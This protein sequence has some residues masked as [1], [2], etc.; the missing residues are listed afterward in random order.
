MIKVTSRGWA[1]QGLTRDEKVISTKSGLNQHFQWEG[2]KE[3]QKF[4]LASGDDDG[5]VFLHFLSYI[6]SPVLQIHPDD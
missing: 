2:W 5:E 3:G 6:F 1:G 4:R